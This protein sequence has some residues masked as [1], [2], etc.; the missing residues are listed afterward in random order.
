MIYENFLSCILAGVIGD[1]LGAP[2]E[3]K[4]FLDE[5]SFWF[6]TDDNQ[7]TLASCE[8]IIENSGEISP[9]LFAKTFLRWYIE[10]KIT[11]IGFTTKF[12]LDNLKNSVHWAFSEKH[13]EYSAGNGTAMRIAPLSFF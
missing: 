4:K 7:M 3:G 1:C 5:S 11:G 13:G 9:E 12:A 6:Y 2:P 10:G 8:A